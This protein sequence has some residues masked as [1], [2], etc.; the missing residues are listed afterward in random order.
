MRFLAIVLIFVILGQSVNGWPFW[1]RWRPPPPFYPRPFFYPP[2]LPPPP[3]FYPPPYYYRNPVGSFL[4][5]A[6]VG[7]LVGGT[8]G[9]FGK[10]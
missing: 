10:K 2:P 9:L 1:R 8:L 6:V 7:G 4:Q 3:M 5:G